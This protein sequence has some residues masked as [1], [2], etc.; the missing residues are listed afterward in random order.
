[1][2]RTTLHPDLDV[3]ATGRVHEATG[4]GRRIFALALAARIAG[5]VLWAQDASARDALYGPGIARFFDPARLI[6]ALPVGR[7]QILQVV[8]EALRSGA[9]PLVI[10][11]VD[12][13]PDLTESRRLQLAAGTGCGRG[14]I[15]VPENRLCTNAAETRWRCTPRSGATETL[16]DWQI[17]KNKRGRLGSWHVRWTGAGFAAFAAPSEPLPSAPQGRGRVDDRP[18]PAS[19]A[20]ALS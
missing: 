16:Q 6:V 2:T 4:S 18:R 3:L 17:I 10:A 15:L 7:L 8:E 9:A 5:P 20:T 19:P 11:E 13:A 12:A 1:M 14:L